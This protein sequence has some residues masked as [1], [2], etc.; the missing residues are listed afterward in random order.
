MEGG[1]NYGY[2]LSRFLTEKNTCPVKSINPLMTN[3]QRHFYG[4]DKTDRLDALA[5]AA[6][7]FRAYDRLP[8]ISPIE[9]A[10]EATREL[11]RYRSQLVKEQTSTLNRLHTQLANQYPAYKSFFSK[12][13]G[14]TALH[15]WYTF[16]TP[17]HLHD[18]SVENLAD[19]IY[20]KSKHTIGKDGSKKKA[21]KILNHLDD[22]PPQILP[23]L[24]DAQSTII[25][26]MAQSLLLL[27]RNIE[28]VQ[29]KLEQALDATGQQLHTMQGI[30]TALAGVLVGETQ[31][32]ARFKHNKDRF[33]SYNGSAPATKGSG[34]Q[35]RQ[36]ENRWCNRHLKTALDH[37]ARGAAAA[38]PLS[39]EYFQSCLDRGLTKVQ[40]Y[41]RLRRR[42]SDIIFAMMRDKTPY[43]PDIHRRKQAQHNKKGKSVA[44]AENG[45]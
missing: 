26:C 5:T 22:C 38:E 45:G 34:K 37:V 4:E 40:A 19:F 18:Q 17:S 25:R 44:P 21:Q 13:N 6:V 41:K 15:F 43:D 3:R 9:E 7:V 1:P 29:A 31:N 32:T 14:L 27:K 30:S 28:S 11:S 16:P 42:L 20:E 23:L 39:A 10:T 12:I 8:D 24:D 35:S 2:S 33:A 36:V